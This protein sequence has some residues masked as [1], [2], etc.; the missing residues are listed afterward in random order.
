[1]QLI[2]YLNSGHSGVETKSTN[3]LTH[4]WSSENDMHYEKLEENG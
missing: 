2:N 4:I 3:D 1:M